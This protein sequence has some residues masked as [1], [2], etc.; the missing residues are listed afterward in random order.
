MFTSFCSVGT[1]QTS[2]SSSGEI[3]LRVELV[4]AMRHCEWIAC[5]SIT[6]F[7]STVFCSSASFS[8]AVWGVRPQGV[9]SSAPF[10]WAVKLKHPVT[11]CVVLVRCSQSADVS[12]FWLIDWCHISSV[13]L[14][15]QDIQ[16]SERRIEFVLHGNDTKTI[17]QYPAVK[18]RYSLLVSVLLWITLF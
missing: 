3:T 8:P 13:V 12:W 11:Q 15:L 7:W 6:S 2:T 5:L 16:K 9:F 4:V 1:I 17:L 14:C 10:R 18:N